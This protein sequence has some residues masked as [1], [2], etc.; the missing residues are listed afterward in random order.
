MKSKTV[1]RKVSEYL[2]YD[3]ICRQGDRSSS[4]RT[5]KH[6][7]YQKDTRK[8]YGTLNIGLSEDVENA[9]IKQR[10]KDYEKQGRSYKEKIK[11]IDRKA[12]KR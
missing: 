10:I 2:K 3:Y 9:E 7:K 4:R 12:R 5:K 6:Q 11:E 1:L 8:R